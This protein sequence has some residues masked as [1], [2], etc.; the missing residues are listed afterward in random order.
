MMAKIKSRFPIF[1]HLRFSNVTSL[2]ITLAHQN[3]PVPIALPLSVHL[4]ITIRYS[5]LAI[6]HLL[7]FHF[8]PKTSVSRSMAS[9]TLR[10]SAYNF[11]GSRS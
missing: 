1:A 10:R 5:P 9:A 8:S 4:P 3:C 6:R 2:P 7:P 11:C